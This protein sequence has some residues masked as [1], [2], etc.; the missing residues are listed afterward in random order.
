MCIRDSSS[1][2]AAIT[3]ASSPLKIPFPFRMIKHLR[4][5]LLI[6]YREA[7]SSSA[8]FSFFP[9]LISPETVS[10]TS[11]TMPTRRSAV[12]L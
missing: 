10:I 5:F 3:S 6:A 9:P 11:G 2:T 1:I 12:L 7:Y 8:G 4:I